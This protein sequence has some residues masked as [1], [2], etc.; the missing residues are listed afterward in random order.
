MKF[1]VDITI[2]IVL[3][4]ILETHARAGVG[5]TDISAVATLRS[6]HTDR[7]KNYNERNWGVGFEKAFTPEWRGMAGGYANSDYGASFYIGGAYLPWRAGSAHLGFAGGI[8]TGY[9]NF[10][11][12]FIAPEAAIEFRHFGINVFAI[13]K[14]GPLN[15]GAGLQIKWKL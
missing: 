12:P 2:V 9:N 3:M 5:V 4:L 13:P 15:G 6:Y 1:L 7:T 10:V 11:V 14:I 8:V